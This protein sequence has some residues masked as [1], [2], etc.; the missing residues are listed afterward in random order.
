MYTVNKCSSPQKWPSSLQRARAEHTEGEKRR[1]EI[2]YDSNEQENGELP[3]HCQNEENFFETNNE[4]LECEE[5]ESTPNASPRRYDVIQPQRPLLDIGNW[6]PQQTPFG[7][8]LVSPR[9]DLLINS[10]VSDNL[11][12]LLNRLSRSKIYLY[13]NIRYDSIT[14][15]S[16]R[17]KREL[18]MRPLC[19]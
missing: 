19:W 4:A 7:R 16:Q 6:L 13:A 10:D 5:G 11:M 12:S 18:K 9:G 15:Y 17:T 3:T 8:V 14:L 2:S 1:R